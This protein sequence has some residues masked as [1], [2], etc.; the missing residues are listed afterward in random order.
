[1]IASERTPDLVC[2]KLLSYW[3]T[4]AVSLHMFS[5]EGRDYMQSFVSLHRVDMPALAVCEGMQM[6]FSMFFL[7]ICT[8]KDKKLAEKFINLTENLKKKI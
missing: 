3:L 6:I 7:L 2:R 4:P 8:S 5:G 1:M